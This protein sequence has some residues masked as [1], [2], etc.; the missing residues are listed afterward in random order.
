MSFFHTYP[1]VSLD[2]I[3]TVEITSFDFPSND[4]CDYVYAFSSPERA[5][6]CRR[7]Y[8]RRVDELT[9][10]EPEYS[11]TVNYIVHDVIECDDDEYARIRDHF[12]GSVFDVDEYEFPR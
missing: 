1:N 10:D 5:V 4:R 11:E 7:Y 8:D 3:Y 2:M 9:C 12:Y 6:A